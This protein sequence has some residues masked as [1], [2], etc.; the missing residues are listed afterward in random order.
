MCLLYSFFTFLQIFL[1]LVAKSGRLTIWFFNG[2][3]RYRIGR[4]AKRVVRSYYIKTFKTLTNKR[5][6]PIRFIRDRAW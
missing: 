2:L 4:T 3:V 1:N 6:Y 5:F